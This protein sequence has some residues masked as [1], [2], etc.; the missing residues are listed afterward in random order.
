MHYYN[1]HDKN[2]V[3]WLRELMAAGLIPQGEIDGRDIQDIRAVE[4][5]GYVQW[6]FFAGIAGWPLAL[7]LA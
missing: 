5:V 3:A 1:E 2:A 7:R 6:H 4:L